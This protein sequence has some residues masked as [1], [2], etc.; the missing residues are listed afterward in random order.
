MAYASTTHLACPVLCT[1]LCLTAL[2]M[3]Y[4]PCGAVL[5]GSVLFTRYDD[6]AK[7]QE[8]VGFRATGDH[9]GTLSTLTAG[10]L[11]F[12]MVMVCMPGLSS[13]SSILT[14]K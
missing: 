11:T 3:L 13:C 10:A 9:F 7:R 5:Q 12:C 8:E 2:T 6:K 4:R 1:W 14:R